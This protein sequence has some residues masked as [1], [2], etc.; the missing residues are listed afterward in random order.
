MIPEEVVPGK[1]DTVSLQEALRLGEKMYQEGRLPS[2]ESSYH[3]RN[4][5]HKVL[6]G[7]ALQV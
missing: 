5:H 3:G 6:N 4:G 2:G 7:M 1:A